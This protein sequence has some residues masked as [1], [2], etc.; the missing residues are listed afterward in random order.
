[1]PDVEPYFSPKINI[2]RINDR[3]SRNKFFF[4]PEGRFFT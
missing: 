1:M 4:A 2:H 3:I